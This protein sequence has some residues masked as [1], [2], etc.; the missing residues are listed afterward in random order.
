ML[1]NA[2]LVSRQTGQNTTSVIESAVNEYSIKWMLIEKFIKRPETAVMYMDM[3]DTTS[4]MLR[5][6]PEIKNW[7]KP[8]AELLR[9]ASRMATFNYRGSVKQ[10]RKQNFLSMLER[11]QNE[12]GALIEEVNQV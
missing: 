8:L 7:D 3:L 4:K 5:G 12:I 2:D 9:T 6:K 11:L 10:Q 1:D